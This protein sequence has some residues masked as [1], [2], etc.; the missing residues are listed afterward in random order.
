METPTARIDT[1]ALTLAKTCRLY[2][3]TLFDFLRRHADILCEDGDDEAGK[4]TNEEQRPMFQV[5]PLRIADACLR[6]LTQDR[7]SRLLRQQGDTWIDANGQSV[8]EHLFLTYSAK[9]WDKHLDLVAPNGIEVS[10]S[11]LKIATG[12]FIAVAVRFNERVQAF[13][14]S[15]NFQTCIQIQSL[16]IIGAFSPY[17]WRN[18]T[19]GRVWVRRTLPRW[20]VEDKY[21]RDYHRF[22]WD[23]QL[24]LSCAGCD[25]PLCAFRQ[26]IGEVDRCWWGALGSDN[27]LSK[28]ESRYRSFRFEA[29]QDDSAEAG[30]NGQCFFQTALATPEGV[31]V[32]RLV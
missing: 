12:A 16:W 9:N 18:S 2:H 1:D 26:Y 15:P 31:T 24:F 25:D 20:I 5:C 30:A 22:W 27:F 29:P 8:S 19:D 32:L 11:S 28:M 17:T 7:Y 4:P 14:A 13:L 21:C 10:F 6:Y 23:W 3:S